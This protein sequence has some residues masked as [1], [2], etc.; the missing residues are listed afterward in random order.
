MRRILLAAVLGFCTPLLGFA[1]QAAQT[2]SDAPAT[3]ED[4]Q[5]YLD[6][7]H[8]REMMAKM[9]DAM[10]APMH[11]MLHEQFLKDKTKLPPDFEDR[12]SKMVDDE[13]KSFPWD[14][15]L[16]S[17]VPVYQKHLTK[18]DVN[19]LVAF[20]GSPTGQKI[21]HDMPAIMQEAMESMMPLMQKQMNTM[22]SRVQQEVAQMM[23]D[24]KPAQKPKSEEIKN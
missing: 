21:L 5:K 2:A 13:M 7:M 3:K 14:E 23:K 9:V 22:N 11:K 16:D 6:V 19:A 17:M 15:M 18:G 1:Q 8:S 12:V 20:Y 4:I 24:Y 10:S